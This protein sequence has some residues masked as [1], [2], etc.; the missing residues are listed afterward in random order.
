[1]G[2]V[3]QPGETKTETKVGE[4]GQSILDSVAKYKAS[5]IITAGGRRIFS[6]QATTAEKLESEAAKAEKTKEAK[7]TA[8]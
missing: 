3:P 4:K 7:Y 2:G 1:M 8:R 5:N 6:S